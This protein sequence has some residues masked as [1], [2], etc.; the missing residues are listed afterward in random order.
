MEHS[1][2]RKFDKSYNYWSVKGWGK[3][4]GELF[5]TSKHIGFF[6]NLSNLNDFE[7]NS[8]PGVVFMRNWAI[9]RCTFYIQLQCNILF[10]LSSL[11][12]ERIFKD[13]FLVLFFSRT[14]KMS[15]FVY[16]IL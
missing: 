3:E 8:S 6:K 15:H 16:K 4:I 12:V 2:W 1:L 7:Y 9:E 5:P 10:T 13:R 11:I 14:G